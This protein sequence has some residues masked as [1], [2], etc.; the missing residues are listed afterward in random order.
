MRPEVAAV[1]I[2]WPAAIALVARG[3]A[4]V[5]RRKQERH[6][7][8]LQA[9]YHRKEAILRARQEAYQIERSLRASTNKTRYG[10]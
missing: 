3:I 4:R 8:D 7:D 2:L 1:A 5:A 9:R 10:R 6:L